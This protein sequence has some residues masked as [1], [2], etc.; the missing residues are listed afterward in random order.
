M[1]IINI[2]TTNQLKEAMK[3]MYFYKGENKI[4]NITKK[5]KIKYV[6]TIMKSY[7]LQKIK[8]LMALYKMLDKEEVTIEDLIMVNNMAYDLR[9]INYYLNY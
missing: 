3:D 5:M 1:K 7:L 9:P 6:K 2:R 4:V 8:L